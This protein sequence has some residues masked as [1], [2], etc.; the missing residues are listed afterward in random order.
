MMTI[1]R[2]R[3]SIEELESLEE[4]FQEFRFNQGGYFLI[5]LFEASVPAIQRFDFIWW[6]LG[7]SNIAER[8]A[9]H[10]YQVLN[11]FLSVFQ[12]NRTIF[13]LS[14]GACALGDP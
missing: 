14:E 5:F 8:K 2:F 9:T 4:Q 6:V 7:A 11:F 10:C 13:C 1:L 12:P 3:F